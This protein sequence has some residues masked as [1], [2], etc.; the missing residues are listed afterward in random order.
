MAKVKILNFTGQIKRKCLN[1]TGPANVFTGL[2]QTL[3]ALGLWTCGNFDPRGF[4]VFSFIE[5]SEVARQ[6][7]ICMHALFFSFCFLYW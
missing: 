4:K 6:L 3:L 5:N 7:G 2:N 1:Y